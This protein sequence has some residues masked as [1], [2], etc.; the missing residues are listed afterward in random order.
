MVDVKRAIISIQA[1]IHAQTGRRTDAYYKSGFGCL[2][3]YE[4]EELTPENVIYAADELE[5]QMRGFT[6]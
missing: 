6:L 5:I 2:F 1:Q 4:Y 3:V